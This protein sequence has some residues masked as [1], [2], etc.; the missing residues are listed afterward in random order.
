M[1]VDYDD[2][3]LPRMELKSKPIIQFYLIA[4]GVALIICGINVTIS[5]EQYITN[6]M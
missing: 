5:R 4:Y 1:I 6:K 3:S 2:I